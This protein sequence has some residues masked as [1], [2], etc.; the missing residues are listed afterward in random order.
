MWMANLLCSVAALRFFFE[1][2]GN[3]LSAFSFNDELIV[4]LSVQI[5]AELIFQGCITE[6][7]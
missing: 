4:L 7:S 1:N 6:E 5:Q 3:S 2:T